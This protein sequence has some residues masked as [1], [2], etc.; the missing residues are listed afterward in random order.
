MKSPSLLGLQTVPRWPQEGTLCPVVDAPGPL[1]GFLSPKSHHLPSP[2]EGQHRQN[3]PGTSSRREVLD[4]CHILGNPFGLL[5]APCMAP[6][7]ARLEEAQRAGR[8]QT[9]P[10]KEKK[11]HRD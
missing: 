5:S 6:D 7:G 4:S 10:C 1:V 3:L 8:Q 11:M 9:K 2:H